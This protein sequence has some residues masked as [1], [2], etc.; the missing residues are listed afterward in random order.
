MIPSLSFFKLRIRLKLEIPDA[1]SVF[2]AV[3]SRLPLHQVT[4]E[5]IHTIEEIIP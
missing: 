4:I 5:F 2:G 1:Y 3:H